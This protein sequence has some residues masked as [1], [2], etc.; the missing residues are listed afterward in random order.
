MMFKLIAFWLLVQLIVLNKIISIHNEI[1]STFPTQNVTFPN[2]PK[3]YRE[4][5]NTFYGV[6]LFGPVDSKPFI[7]HNKTLVQIIN[8][9]YECYK[10]TSDI[11]IGDL[12]V[13]NYT[14]F[15]TIDSIRGISLSYKSDSESVSLIH[16]LYQNKQIDQLMFTLD[17]IT[18]S[19]HFGGVPNNTMA[20]VGHCDVDKE[21]P[22]WGC[23]LTRIYSDNKSLQMNRLAVIQSNSLSGLAFY[24]SDLYKFKELFFQYEIENKICERFVEGSISCRIN[25]LNYDRVIN[26]EF[27]SMTISFT[28]REL[29]SEESKD[30]V[31]CFS[32]FNNRNSRI[33]KDVYFLFGRKIVSQ[34]DY[35][36]FDYEKSQ[37]TFYSDT[38]KI[39]MNHSDSRYYIFL[40]NIGI[41]LL[42][43]LYLYILKKYTYFYNYVYI[44]RKL[45]Y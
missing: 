23:K 42:Q 31:L 15:L 21:Q 20:Y 36:V 19:V 7:N 1:Y 44:L 22:Y 13:F 24:R 16:S 27:G 11:H 30:S 43:I 3:E 17:Y 26:F 29:F 34:F 28:V 8:K 5:F 40:C 33:E 10:I 14:Y 38:I 25:L 2:D 35:A 39:T 18:N 4:T 45:K 12:T 32:Y 9:A 41:C 6:S 37:I